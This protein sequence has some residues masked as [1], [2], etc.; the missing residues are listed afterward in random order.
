MRRI[1]PS[2]L[3]SK[4]PGAETATDSDRKRGQG[5]EMGGQVGEVEIS[6]TWMEARRIFGLRV[7]VALAPPT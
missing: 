4:T 2:P 7:S 6:K 3:S 5:V 1:K